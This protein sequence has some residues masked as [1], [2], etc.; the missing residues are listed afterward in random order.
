M[1]TPLH[2]RLLCRPEVEIGGKVLA[3]GSCKALPRAPARCWAMIVR[4]ALAALAA[5]LLTLEAAGRQASPRHAVEFV[6]MGRTQVEAAS[7][8]SIAYG[9]GSSALPS[10]WVGDFINKTPSRRTG[11]LFTL[12]AR[13][14]PISQTGFT[15][16][17][18][19]EVAF[20][21]LEVGLREPARI[22]V[23]FKAERLEPHDGGGL[24][25]V[26][27]RDYA[28]RMRRW[29]VAAFR[30]RIDGV[31]ASRAGRVDPLVFKQ[32][33]AQ[34]PVYPRLV[35]WLPQA[36]AAGFATNAGPRSGT[37]EFLS[38]D[39]ARALFTLRFDGLMPARVEP[40]P[41]AGARLVRAELTMAGAQFSFS[42]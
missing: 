1:A 8:S 29:T 19:T 40:E 24:I 16:A 39:R 12:S 36:D 2:A 6:G 7:E 30:V 34:V 9:A 3:F 33:P 17:V 14:E 22:T 20:P 18:V 25:A 28:A 27:G 10:Q 21:A 32:G 11:F 42:P 31:D 35:I 38:A 15:R 23:G 41:A 13:G 4:P 37:L 5:C 26:P